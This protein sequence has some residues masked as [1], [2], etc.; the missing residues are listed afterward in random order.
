VTSVRPAAPAETRSDTLG[1]NDTAGAPRATKLREAVFADHSEIADLEARFGLTSKSYEAWCDLWLGNPVYRT[2]GRDWSIGW[3]LED[4]DGHVVASMANIPLAYELEGRPILAA[5]GSN[6]VAEPAYRSAALLLLDGVIN[7][8]GVELY[9]NNT[10]TAASV[11][12]VKAFE[13]VPVPVGRWDRAG[14]WYTDRQA[15]YEARLRGRHSPFARSLSYALAAPVTLKDRFVTKALAESD[16]EVQASAGF[17]ERFDDFWD[18]LRRRYPHRLMAVRTREALAWHYRHAL[19]DGHLWIATVVD[20]RRL[21]AF[22]TFRHDQHPVWG[23]RMRL[24]DFQSLDDGVELLPALLSWALRRCRADGIHTLEVLGSW[25]GEGELL[26]HAAPHP[27]A[28]PTWKFFYRA[29]TPALAARL[30]DPKAWA[31]SLYDGDA[32]L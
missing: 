20:G 12:A 18:E 26:E 29:N 15:Y 21:V 4:E 24:A 17:D 7:Q 14:V 23:T 3:V 25:L 16:V 27:R 6:W 13:C 28:L 19:L 22:A 5:S 2:L 32:T 9:V 10:V 31:P 1:S 11:A 30:R 8:R